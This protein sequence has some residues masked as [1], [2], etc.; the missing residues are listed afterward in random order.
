VGAP[1]ARLQ[2][3]AAPERDPPSRSDRSVRRARPPSDPR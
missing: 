2:H 3:A 1:D